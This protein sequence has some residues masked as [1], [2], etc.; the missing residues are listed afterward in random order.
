M[1]L[2]SLLIPWYKMYLGH[3]I[4]CAIILEQYLFILYNVWTVAVCC[5]ILS[6]YCCLSTLWLF[7]STYCLVIKTS[8]VSI[9]WRTIGWQKILRSAKLVRIWSEK[10]KEISLSM[11][12]FW[13]CQQR[14][15]FS[16]SPSWAV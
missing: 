14:I 16:L 13:S 9:G 1:R 5:I 2:G 8:G 11:L 6:F 10:R 15:P 12:L 4:R 3:I 7:P